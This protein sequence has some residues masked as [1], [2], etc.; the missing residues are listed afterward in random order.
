MALYR[1]YSGRPWRG[2]GKREVDRKEGKDRRGDPGGSLRRGMYAMRRVIHWC[3]H[4]EKVAEV[5]GVGLVMDV[6]DV[7]VFLRWC[8]IAVVLRT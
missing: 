1:T 2:A 8:C 5:T 3:R 4:D 7:R 6:R